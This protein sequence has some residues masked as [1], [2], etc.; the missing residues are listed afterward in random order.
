LVIVADAPTFFVTPFREW[1]D[2]LVMLPERRGAAVARNFALGERSPGQDFMILDSDVQVTTDGWLKQL[3]TT[4]YSGHFGAVSPCLGIPGPPYFAGI[5]PNEGVREVANLPGTKL[6]KGEVMDQLGYLHSYGL[7]G[8]E[9]IDLDARITALGYGLVYDTD[10]QATHPVIEQMSNERNDQMNEQMFIF[11]NWEDAYREGWFLY[12]PQEGHYIPENNPR[13]MSRAEGWGSHLPYLQAAV[14]ST[15]GP[16]I[17]VGTGYY[18]TPFLMDVARSGREV[19]AVE[20]D[21]RWRALADERAPEGYEVRD[22]IP[23]GEFSVALIDGTED[24]R[25]PAVEALAD[26][27]EFLVCHD[28]EEDLAYYGTSLDQFKHRKD[29]DSKPRTSVVSNTRRFTQKAA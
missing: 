15:K 4:L 21:R 25:A 16:V 11:K 6:I 29:F 14:A 20:T 9:D 27:T 24:S 26:R 13:W 3:Q 1:A 23:D 18:S 2:L 5:V 10:I 28:T 19:V 8:Y 22:D 17:E 7:Y 12:C